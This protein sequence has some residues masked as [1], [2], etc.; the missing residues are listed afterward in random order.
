MACDRY[1]CHGYA[2][3]VVGSSKNMTGGLLISSSAIAKRFLWPPDKDPVFVS[4]R[5]SRPSIVNVL[6]IC[7]NEIIKNHDLKRRWQEF[8]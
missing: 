8:F 1:G 2:T 7:E 4:I 5:F 6:S 3:Y